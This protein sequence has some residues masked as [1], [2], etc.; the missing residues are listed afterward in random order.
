MAEILHTYA[1]WS[2]AID[3]LKNGTDDEQVLEAMQHGTLEWQSGVAERFLK[4]LIEAVNYRMDAASDRFQLSMSRAR[5]EERLIIQALIALRKEMSYL[6][7]VVD[8]PALPDRERARNIGLVKEQADNMQNSLEDS[9]RNDRTGKLSGII[10]GHR[11][12]EQIQ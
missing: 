8:I 11:I 2:A 1:D 5:G 7:K 3:K 10:R 9:A 6:V 12:N 4:K